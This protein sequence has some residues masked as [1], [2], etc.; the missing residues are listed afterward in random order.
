MKYD[1]LKLSDVRRVLDAFYGHS[2][3]VNERYSKENVCI[4][5]RDRFVSRFF[6]KYVDRYIILIDREVIA[7]RFKNGFMMCEPVS[8]YS[9]GFDGCP[10]GAT[11]VYRNA[12]K[13]L[14]VKGFIAVNSMRGTDYIEMNCYD[15]VGNSLK[16]KIDHNNLM[17]MQFKEILKSEFEMWAMLFRD[18]RE[19]IPFKVTRYLTYDEI[20]ERNTKNG[21]TKK[22]K[23]HLVQEQTVVMAMDEDE[24]RNMMTNVLS[25]ERVEE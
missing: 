19:P 4:S 16:F 5:D 25:V 17:R 22:I 11:P 21:K 8:I 1:M 23:E 14:H 2:S 12:K 6:R 18:D 9:K 10:A 24:A 20:K 7:Y 15:M 3:C 13:F